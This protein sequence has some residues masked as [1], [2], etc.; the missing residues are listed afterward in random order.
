MAG[1][2]SILPVRLKLLTLPKESLPGIMHAVVRNLYFRR[3]DTFFSYT[4]NS[5]EVSIVADVETVARDFP[6]P[7]ACPGLV[8]C[9]DPF[10]ALQ[11]DSEYNGLEDSGK[12][13]N[14]LSA[15]LARAGISIFYLSTYQTD[16]VFVKEK[17]IPLV[18]S[19]LE[20][21]GFE[22][23]DLEDLDIPL[24]PTSTPASTTTPEP[25]L[26]ASFEPPSH[27]M[28]RTNGSV[29]PRSLASSRAGDHAIVDPRLL[30]KKLVPGN[31]LRLVGLNREYVEG[32][33]MKIVRI[34]FYPEVLLDGRRGSRASTSVDHRLFSYTSTEEGI[35]LVADETV[36]E[37]FSEHMLNM[38]VTPRPLKCIQVDLTAQ[39]MEA[40]GTDRY[41]IVYSMADPLA[42]GGINLLFLSTFMTSNV[43]VSAADLPRALAILHVVKEDAALKS[44]ISTPKASPNESEFESRSEQSGDFFGEWED[45]Q[46]GRSERDEEDCRVES[47]DEEEGKDGGLVYGS[48]DWEEEGEGDSGSGSGEEGAEE[49]RKAFEGRGVAIATKEVRELG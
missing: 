26:S 43:L 5:L 7:A 9:E 36:L 41:G 34:I 24:T 29:S 12:R 40:S 46:N 32:W 4:E 23:A 39:G 22:F 48:E 33:A 38:S 21:T 13:I 37:Q 35:S 18:I 20:S 30:D 25:S 16:F 3:R 27:M 15:P 44:P 14:Q 31:T 47:S 2:I 11:I 45:D 10:R 8:V 6:K 1:S 19:V 17:R 42:A 28:D 49:V